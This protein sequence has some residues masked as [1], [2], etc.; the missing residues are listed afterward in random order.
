MS[1]AVSASS[2]LETLGRHVRTHG[3][4]VGAVPNK[5][6][7]MP[8]PSRETTATLPGVVGRDSELATFDDLLARAGSGNPAVAVIRGESGCGKTHLLNVLAA[9]AGADGW[10]CLHVQGVESEAVLSGAGLLSLLSPLRRGLHEVPEAQADAL[11]G[12]L[13]WGPATGFGDRFLVGAGTLSL[14]AVES[15]RTPL[16]ISVDDVQWV[17]A[18]SAAAV[19]FAVRRLGH[20]RVAVAM[21][22]RVGLPLPVPLDHFEVIAVEGLDPGAARTL[23][24]PGFSA[25]VVAR[26]VSE[27]E[28]IRWRCA[29]A[30]GCSAGRNKREPHLCPRPCPFPTACVRCTT[31]SW[32]AVTGRVARRCAVRGEQRPGRGAAACGPGC[33]GPRARRVLGRGGSGSHHPR[34]GS[35][36]SASDAAVGDLGACFGVRASLGTHFAGHGHAGPGSS[37]VAPGRGH[38][39]PGRGARRG[40]GRCSRCGPLAPWLRRRLEGHGTRGAADSGPRSSR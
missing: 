14:L 21:T 30:S 6:R 38:A 24:G 1:L 12:A 5:V 22:H 40:I 28:E 36:V 25:D 35:L 20:D 26:L 18:E 8:T 16:F 4:A 19:A 34:W 29:N 39:R 11:S 17:D 7:A 23:L 13:G 32:R 27:T 10:K 3:F 2:P 9:R 37:G 31:T 33:R 15:S